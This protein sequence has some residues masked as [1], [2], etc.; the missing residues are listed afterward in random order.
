[1]TTLK[2][3]AQNAKGELW[4]LDFIDL[5]KAEIK[6][7]T[8]NKVEKVNGNEISRQVEY[9]VVIIDGEE[10]TIR[11]KQLNQLK[12]ILEK[13]PLTKKVRLMK[14]DD[15]KLAWISLE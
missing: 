4:Q 7:R 3:A 6:Q 5:D 8:F 11:E 15:G 10:Y 12:E 13:K 14:L 2:E 1:M 9:K